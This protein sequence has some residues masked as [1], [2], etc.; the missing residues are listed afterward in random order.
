MKAQAFATESKFL[1]NALQQAAAM[2]PQLAVIFG[3]APLWENKDF[4][5]ALGSALPGASVIGCSTAGEI[6]ADDAD[7]KD[8][9]GLLLRFDTATVKT[10]SARLE[11][12]EDSYGAG[13]AIGDALK[14]PDLRG[15]F[16][17]GPG[18]GVNGTAL[19]KG[20]SDAVGKGV[21]ITGGL[22]GD[23]LRFAAT[24]TF[25]NGAV[26]ADQVVAFGLYGDKVFMK[27]AQRSGWRPF[28]PV[29]RVTRA[30]ANMI[31]ELDGK[32]P[33]Q[34]YR[35]YLGDDGASLP[36]AGALYPFSIL[37]EEDRAGTGL[38]RIPL[39]FDEREGGMALAGEVPQGSLLRLMHADEGAL[40]AAAAEACGDASGAALVVSC[41]GRKAVFGEDGA[42]RAAIAQ[43]LGQQAA[44]AG[45]YSYGSIGALP[46]AVGPDVSNQVISVVHI[47]ESG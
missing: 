21:I 36:A 8:C 30:S 38:I 18:L 44:F 2:K 10:A 19:S 4:L 3:A 7:G 1:T 23:G 46:G 32:P 22:A 42:E 43:A 33:L 24:R 28:G 6:Y 9:T 47:G 20:I 31:H 11:T 12:V 16:M 13:R 37:R 40:L 26:A 27:S 29:R 5:A 14:A 17:L 34:L 25:L 39:G 45:L 41:A 15:I 35:E